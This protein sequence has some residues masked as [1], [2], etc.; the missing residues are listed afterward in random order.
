VRRR[1]FPGLWALWALSLAQLAPAQ[2]SVAP[3][4]EIKVVVVSMFEIGADTGDMAGEFQLWHD[5]Q[6]LTQRFAFAHHHDLFLNPAT[7]VLG[8]VTGEGTANSATAMMELGMDPRFDLSHAYWLVAGIAG[9]NPK[10]ASIGSAAWARYI[11]DGDLAYQIDSREIPRDW[12]TGLYP[13]ES[14]RPFDPKAQP[15]EGQMFELTPGLVQWAYELTRNV[16]LV[17]DPQMRQLRERYHEPNARRPP[18]VLL[19]DNIAAMRFWDGRLMNDWAE[20]WVKFWTHGKGEMVTSA[21]EDSGTL[22]ALTFLGRSGRVDSHRVLVLRTG[23]DFA[24]PPPGEMPAQALGKEADNDYAALGPAV[25]A[26]YRV[27]APVVDALVHDWATYKEHPPQPR[28]GA[29]K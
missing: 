19:G 7:G 16:V 8:M 27:G 25:E 26:A 1:L 28:A 12:S 15:A 10:Y 14:K 23:S 3:P 17:D 13:L 9:I 20:R 24:V 22:V 21:M 18:F 2:S 4:I 11:V 29:P 6:Q 5:R